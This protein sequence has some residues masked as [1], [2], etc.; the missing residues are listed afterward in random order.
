ML[1]YLLIYKRIEIRFTKEFEMREIAECFV[2]ARIGTKWFL[3]ALTS[4]CRKPLRFNSGRNLG[5]ESFRYAGQ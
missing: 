2:A 5:V 3:A 1:K 4:T